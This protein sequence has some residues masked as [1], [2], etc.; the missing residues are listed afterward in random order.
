M[1]ANGSDDVTSGLNFDRKVKTLSVS[2]LGGH[3]ETCHHLVV[4]G[5][6]IDKFSE[7]LS[8]VE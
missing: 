4:L 8:V 6:R 3:D 1:C 7:E 5:L 2:Q